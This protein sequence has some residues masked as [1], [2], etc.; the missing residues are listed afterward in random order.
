MLESGSRRV[1]FVPKSK[2]SCEVEGIHRNHTACVLDVGNVDKHEYI[3]TDLSVPDCPSL[4]LWC[5]C[6]GDLWRRLG[7][8]YV[9][10]FIFSLVYSRY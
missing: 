2:V 5:V 6:G 3:D 4:P 9:Y 7:E 10:F 1:R 8:I